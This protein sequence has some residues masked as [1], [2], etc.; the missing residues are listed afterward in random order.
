M[1][2]YLMLTFE[3]YLFTKGFIQPSI[4]Y[5]HNPFSVARDWSV[6]QLTMGSGLHPGGAHQS[7]IK[8]TQINIYTYGQS[9]FQ[10]T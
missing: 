9:G 2:S 8:Q 5:T 4:I 3:M 10:S 1:S 7:N 6:S